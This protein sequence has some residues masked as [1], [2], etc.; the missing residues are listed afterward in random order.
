M[1]HISLYFWLC[2]WLPALMPSYAQAPLYDLDEDYTH[3]LRRYE[4]KG[5]HW[6]TLWHYTQLPANRQALLALL[7]D[8]SRFVSTAD[9]FNRRYLQRDN[10]DQSDSLARLYERKT[11]KSFWG[12]FYRQPAAL[13]SA[14]VPGF[15]LSVNPV[16]DFQAGKDSRLNEWTYQNTRGVRLRGTI[17]DRLSFFTYLT[18]TQARYPLYVQQYVDA[19]RALPHEG[20]FK[21]GD[22][23]S[24]TTYDFLSARGYI[25]FRLLPS[26]EVQFGHD[27]NF[28]GYGK[29]S[30]ILSDFAAPYSFLKIT[31]RVWKVQYQNI[32]AEMVADVSEADGL[33]P[34]KYF[35]FHHLSTYL[36]PRLEVGL[37]ESVV[38]GRQNGFEWHYLNPIIFYRSVEQHVGSPD[39]VILGGDFRWMPLPRLAIYGQVVIDELIVAEVR[40]G[41][42]WWG[43]KQAL[44][45]GLHYIDA[46]GI[47]NLDLQ[48]EANMVR[49]YTYTQDTLT[50]A[51]THYRQPL[52]HPAG[53]NFY[54]LLGIVRYQPLPR[55]RLEGQLF[56][57]VK[58][59]DGPGENWGGNILLDNRSR[60]QEYGNRLAQGLRTTTALA[61]LRATYQAYHNL[62]VEASYL[63]RRSVQQGDAENHTSFVSVG[64]RLNAARRR[65]EF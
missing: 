22:R 40:S 5:Q 60:M 25:A 65:A 24:P 21:D 43:N 10:W 3:L 9:R 7:Q 12:H 45:L 62:F 46:F 28:I 52:A 1:K 13:Y 20:Y 57:R 51:Y 59:E 15:R 37:F 54:E 29:R 18:D 49:P 38:F 58:G 33:R 4:L 47:D 30:L 11:D 50:K 31:T 56:Y 14:R 53:A 48:A 64:L 34:K 26:V 42:G 6:D 39:N 8:S 23:P 36:T 16:L 32:F 2:C 35:A 41:K 55:W 19:T 17:D 27:R 63:L 44:Q 61:E